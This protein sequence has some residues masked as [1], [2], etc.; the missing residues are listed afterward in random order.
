MSQFQYWFLLFFS[1]IFSIFSHYLHKVGW[2]FLLLNRSSLPLSMK[3]K[4]RPI[5][6]KSY[7]LKTTRQIKLV[8]SCCAT[9]T[10]TKTKRAIF[11]WIH[12]CIT[13]SP[14]NFMDPRL[15]DC[16]KGYSSF[17]YQSTHQKGLVKKD[18]LSQSS[19]NWKLGVHNK[20]EGKHLMVCQPKMIFWKN[21]FVLLGAGGILNTFFFWQTWP[22]DS[23]AKNERRKI[24]RPKHCIIMKGSFIYTCFLML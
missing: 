23:G 22:P 8:L 14:G 19:Q 3:W 15:K 5:L 21:Q 17:I 20:I 6:R 12:I 4:S 9:K 16:I 10:N 2:G 11:F 13:M 1:D 7:F 24:A 18:R